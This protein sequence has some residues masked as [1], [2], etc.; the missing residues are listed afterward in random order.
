MAVK[1]VFETY[2]YD[3]GLSS[4]GQMPFVLTRVSV[5]HAKACGGMPHRTFRKDEVFCRSEL[6]REGHQHTV[7]VQAVRVIV[8]VFREQARSYRVGR[9]QA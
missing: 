3:P 4:V 7:L 8:D 2:V 9:D 1:Q 5:R 6:A